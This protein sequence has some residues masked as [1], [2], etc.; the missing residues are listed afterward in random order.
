MT[1]MGIKMLETVIR[2]SEVFKDFITFEKGSSQGGHSTHNGVDVL[3]IDEEGN[4]NG[5]YVRLYSWEKLYKVTG[6]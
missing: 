3:V 4:G 5:D 2:K 1:D 6:N